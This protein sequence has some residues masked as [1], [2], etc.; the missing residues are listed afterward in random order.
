MAMKVRQTAHDDSQRQG[1]AG[2]APASL[3]S[4]STRSAIASFPPVLERNP[5][6]RLLYAELGRQGFP[7]AAPSKLKLRWLWSSRK[8]IAVLHFHW[9]QGYWRYNRDPR[10]LGGALSGLT[11]IA[12]A[13]RLLLARLL[14]YRVVW[15][16]HQVY[17]HE[18]ACVRVDRWGATTLAALSHLLLAHDAATAR[19]VKQELGRSA[20]KLEIVPHGSYIGVYPEGRERSQV[21][22]DLDIPDDAVVFLCFG[23]VRAYKE[24]G[25]LLSA[26]R[27]ADAPD[28]VL[29]V[30]GAVGN[31]D[32]AS[33]VEAAIA[34]DH[35]IRPPLGFVPDG[36]V[37]ELFAASDV[38]VLS[39]GDGGTSGALVLALSMGVPVVSAATET[40]GELSGDE[41][42][43]W[44]FV[45][46]DPRSLRDAIERAA[47]SSREEREAMG[48]AALRR[49]ELLRWPEI[50]ERTAS[51]LRTIR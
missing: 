39:R 38:A 30:A 49:A 46:G 37:A 45:P 21:R 27:L 9:P 31:G 33:S 29:L 19:S 48:E 44:T 23:D 4:A 7:L 16:V 26:F 32:A 25:I 36:Q 51:L 42:T 15:T 12:F 2:H 40:Y 13:S 50:A 20:R 35:R 24:I 10:R 8:E 18:L 3:A 43:G 28:A 14:G 22:A 5:Y 41:T 34:A 47:R 6:Q 17:P 1:V 11:T